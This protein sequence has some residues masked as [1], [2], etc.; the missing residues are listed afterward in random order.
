MEKCLEGGFSS[1]LRLSDDDISMQQHQLSDNQPISKSQNLTVGLEQRR[2]SSFA[3][4]FDSQ[5]FGQS[6]L[7]RR[8]FTWSHD[9]REGR[10]SEKKKNDEENFSV[11]DPGIFA[12]SCNNKTKETSTKKKLSKVQKRKKAKMIRLPQILPTNWFFSNSDLVEKP[13]GRNRTVSEGTE[14]SVSIESNE[15]EEESRKVF[16]QI[17]NLTQNLK[18]KFNSFARSLSPS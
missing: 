9:E 18:F 14:S 17:F 13:R 16:V 7:S 12:N 11:N 15:E 6:L 8:H 3:D 10:A 5:D 1:Q 2:N 4:F